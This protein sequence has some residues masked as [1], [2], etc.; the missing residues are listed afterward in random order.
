MNKADSNTYTDIGT[1]PQ[2]TDTKDGIHMANYG[3]ACNGNIAGTT[4]TNCNYNCNCVDN[5]TVGG[6]NNGVCGGGGGAVG[7]TSSGNCCCPCG[8]CNCGSVGGTSQ[9]CPDSLLI[10]IAIVLLLLALFCGN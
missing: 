2:F 8:N 3:C 5:G 1:K 10:I 4:D 7:G 6:T 9:S